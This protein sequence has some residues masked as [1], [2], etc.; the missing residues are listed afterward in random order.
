MGEGVLGI[1]SMTTRCIRGR[2]LAAASPNAN[3]NDNSAP[4][5]TAPV[6]EVDLQQFARTD[7]QLFEALE[8]APF[9]LYDPEPQEVH[10]GLVG[11]VGRDVI[12]ALRAPELWCLEHGAHIGR[13]LVEV[14]ILLRWMGQQDPSI[15]KKYQDF[16]SGKAKLYAR[17]FQ[18]IPDDAVGPDLPAAIKELENLSHNDDFDL[19]TV[20]TGNC[21]RQVTSSNGRRVRTSRL[22]GE[23]NRSSRQR[24]RRPLRRLTSRGR[25]GAW[26]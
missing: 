9:R 12:T 10:A 3:A 13:S 26:C 24:Q 17:I 6:V 16:G 23:F 21:F 1:H 14:N 7:V 25:V 18:E 4:D 8:T 19:R 20:D 11:R 2:D 22:L 15:Y 5:T